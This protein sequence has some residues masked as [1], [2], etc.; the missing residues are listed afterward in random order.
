MS[1]GRR[2]GSTICDVIE[3]ILEDPRYEEM[4]YLTRLFLQEAYFAEYFHEL[5]VP[6]AE[7]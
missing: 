7:V 3:D 1:R 2:K 5:W 4:T 6:N